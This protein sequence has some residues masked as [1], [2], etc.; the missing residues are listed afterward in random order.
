MEIK[1]ISDYKQRVEEGLE[2]N[3]IQIQKP[4]VF[5]NPETLKSFNKAIEWQKD[6][7]KKLEEQILELTKK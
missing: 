5:S 7:I 2:Y 1:I 3:L 6:M 4:Y